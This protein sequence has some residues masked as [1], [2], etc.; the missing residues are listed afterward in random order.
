MRREVGRVKEEG[1]P[2]GIEGG[3]SGEEMEVDSGAKG[4]L[5]MASRPSVCKREGRPQLTLWSWKA[6]ALLRQRPPR[7]PDLGIASISAVW[8]C[9]LAVPGHPHVPHSRVWGIPQ[10]QV[11]FPRKRRPSRE[12][13]H[14]LEGC[15]ALTLAA[16]PS[17]HHNRHTN[18]LCTPETVVSSQIDMRFSCDQKLRPT[19]ITKTCL[20]QGDRLEPG[21]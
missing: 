20:S 12:A 11:L 1:Y 10:S 19:L 2:E 8:R 14:A 4:T 3:E 15:T 5:A 16:H 13:A 18:P 9:V 17:S 6:E 7:R 21:C